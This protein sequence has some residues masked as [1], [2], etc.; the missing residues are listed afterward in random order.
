[1][2]LPLIGYSNYSLKRDTTESIE[3]LKVVGLAIDESN[4]AL[5]GVEVRLFRKNDE[6]EQIEI[7]NVEHHD[8]SFNFTLE[9]NEYYTVEVSKPGYVTR[10]VAFYTQLPREVEISSMFMYEFDVI[11]L[12]EKQ[13]DDYYLDF[14]V[15]LIHY[16]KKSEAFESNVKY[17]K[18]IKAKIAESEEAAKL[19][20]KLNHLE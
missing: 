19:G 8:H 2:L 13:M 3:C 9:A 16:N 7:T 6:M 14:P 12:K 15:A 1:M 4:I 18:Y 17:T 11:L 10:R 20:K 5:D